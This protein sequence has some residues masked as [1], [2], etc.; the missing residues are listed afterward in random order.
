[1][2]QI[3]E[4]FYTEAQAAR[5]LGVNRITVWR[6]IRAGKFDAQKIG[7]EVIIPRWQVDLLET[8]PQKVNV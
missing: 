1:M 6:W 8:K 4:F 2:V 7:R 3:S 5:I